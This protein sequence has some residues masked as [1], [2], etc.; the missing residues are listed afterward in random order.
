MQ[1]GIVSLLKRLRYTLGT[2]ASRVFLLSAC[3]FVLSTRGS[4][5][6]SP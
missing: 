3:L 2:L 6:T 4:L 1:T 5:K